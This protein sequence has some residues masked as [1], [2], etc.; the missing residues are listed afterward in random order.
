M[1]RSRWVPGVAL[2]V[3]LIVFAILRSA[4]TVDEGVATALARSGP[5]DLTIIETGALQALQSVSYASTIQSNQAKIVALAPEGKV[6]AKGDLLI[7]F[8]STP[9]EGQIRETEAAMAQ[10]TNE[11]IGT[12]QDLA[13]QQLQNGEEL[14]TAH[15]KED[16]SGLELR[17]VEEGKGRVREEEAKAELA[18]ADRQLKRAASARDGLKP[19]LDQGFITRQEM[20]RA[21]QEV[22][23]AQE[24]LTIA[25]RRHDSFFEFGRPLERSQARAEALSSRESSKALLS[26]AASRMEQRRAA[27]WGAES[28]IR[29]TEA[30]L[31][32]AKAQLARC[33]VRADVPGIVVYRPVAFGS[34]QRKPQV[35]DQVWANQP[36]LILPDISRMIVEA[37]VR[38]TD[39]HRVSES[40]KVLVRVSAYPDLLL[41][42]RVSLVGTLAQDDIGRRAGKYFGITVEINEQDGRLRPGMTATVEIQVERR[43]QAIFVPIQAVFERDGKKAVYVRELG[44]F[45]K[46]LVVTGSVNRDFAVIEKGISAGDRVALSDP[47][48]AGAHDR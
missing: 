46:R 30:R 44:R 8:D 47:N 25:Q 4:G 40:Q 1:T 32:L 43:P 10:A 23:K 6:V 15:Q 16:R 3:V 48:L 33:E 45:Q 19:L 11:L 26:A 41:T 42:G 39:I 7:L 36:L 13:L 9:F 38:E 18:E 34:E 2:V 28:R 31:A 35:G 20:E 14:A 27:I 29:E 37:R 5:F 22:E 12:R 17:D 21:D 24:K